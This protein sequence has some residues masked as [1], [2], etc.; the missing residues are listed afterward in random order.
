[1]AHFSSCTH[2]MLLITN[3]Y[4]HIYE[5]GYPPCGFDSLTATAKCCFCLARDYSVVLLSS[6]HPLLFAISC[7][8]LGLITEEASFVGSCSQR[9]FYCHAFVRIKL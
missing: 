2:H 7:V 1:M 9:P 6:H 5:V 4:F 3:V 8:G